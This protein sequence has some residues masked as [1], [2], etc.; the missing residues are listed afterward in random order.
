MQDCVVTT[1]VRVL[2]RAVPSE[3]GL[4]IP[5]QHLSSVDPG[6]MTLYLR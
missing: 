4:Q 6:L 2:F 1:R 3:N 5:P